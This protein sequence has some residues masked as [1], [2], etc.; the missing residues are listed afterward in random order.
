MKKLMGSGHK[1]VYTRCHTEKHEPT[2]KKIEIDG[3]NFSDEI[4]TH[5]LLF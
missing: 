1:K 2:K 4:I 3:E 5:Y